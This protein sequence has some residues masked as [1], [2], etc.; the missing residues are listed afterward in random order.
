M[1]LQEKDF[2]EN[3]FRKVENDP[4]FHFEYDLISKET[5]IELGLDNNEIPMLLFGDTGTNKGF[6]VFTGYCFVWIN[7]T[8]PKQAVEF[9]KGFRNF[10]EL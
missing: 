1:E 7:V 6:C 4:C 8:S 3:G 5:I 2:I 10:E 9:S